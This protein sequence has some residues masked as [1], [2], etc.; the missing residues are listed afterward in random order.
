MSAETI[1]DTTTTAETTVIQPDA[2]P[3]G[4]VNFDERVKTDPEFAWGT[5]QNL[6]RQVTE[7][8]NRLKPL[9]QLEQVAK[10]TFGDVA[11]GVQQII[12][13]ADRAFTI[14]KN[15]N[16]KRYVDDALAGRQPAQSTEAPEEYL[17]PEERKIKVLETELESLKGQFAVTDT[18]IAKSELQRHLEGFFQSDLGRALE[19]SERQDVVATLDAQFSTWGR[20]PQGRNV[21]NNLQPDTIDTIVLQKLHKD[22]TL[23]NVY[24]RMR[25]ASVQKLGSAATDSPSLSSRR[26]DDVPEVKQAKDALRVAAQR[27]LD[28]ADRQKLG[29]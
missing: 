21:I 7:K 26:A 15:A 22:G 6:Q 9:E 27:F 17:T 18:R 14:D 3:N 8:T 11:S 2:K 4:K 23:P 20:T 16:L 29:W 19:P 24:E 25:V 28:P 1:P 13:L 5:V 10:A 12:G